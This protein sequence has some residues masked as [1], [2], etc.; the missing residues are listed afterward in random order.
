MTITYETLF[1]VLRKEKNHEDLQNLDNAFISEVKKYIEDKSKNLSEKP[2]LD[3][4]MEGYENEQAALRIQLQNIRKLVKDL[5]DRRE[6][7]I[8][9]M[10]INKAKTGSNIVD[11]SALLPEEKAFFDEQIKAIASFRSEVLESMLIGQNR[12]KRALETVQEPK[13]LNMEPSETND[14]AF[15]KVQ[16]TES[17]PKFV[18]VDLEIY[19][20]F[21]DQEEVELSPEIAEMLV[22]TNKARVV[23][24]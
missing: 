4:F 23:E 12:A 8:I 7:K 24:Q 18:G 17:V 6:R 21:S 9:D 22:K 5:F 15:K 3:Q 13:E 20:P 10:A 11:T 1:E 19:G 2:R 16:I 14:K